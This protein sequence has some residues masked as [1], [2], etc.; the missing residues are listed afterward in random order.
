[1]P[2][3][4]VT[5]SV[6]GVTLDLTGDSP[7]TNTELFEIF[8]QYEQKPPEQVPEPVEDQSI[9]RSVADVPLQFATGIS[10]GVR[11]IS[12]AFGADNAVSQNLR[13]VE[14]YLGSLL[15]AQAQNDRE[16]VGR[17]FQEAQDKGLGEQLAAGLRAIAVS[18]VDFLAQG[19]G[20]AVPT[21]AGGLA[22]AALRGGTLAARAA[23]AKQ[24][25]TGVGV[26]GGAGLTKSTIYDEVK[27]ELSALG[28]LPKEVIEE[29][30]RLAQE[31]GGE[32]LDQILL[33]AGLG[34][35]A[36]GTGIEKVLASRILKNA[37]ARTTGV[38][39]ATK[40]AAF[41]GAKE[42][43]PEFIQA[44][45]EQIAG[46]VALQREG[47][48]DIPTMR[49]VATAAALEGVIGF[50]LG[51]GI[52]VALPAQQ[53]Q[54]YDAARANITN[55][56]DREREALLLA[57]EQKKASEF[58]AALERNNQRRLAGQ[59]QQVNIDA[60][61]AAA[62][63]R[64]SEIAAPNQDEV[65]ELAT[66][67]RG[68][69]VSND[70][71]FGVAYGQKIARTLGDYFPNFGQFSVREGEIRGDA[72]YGPD[73]T[74]ISLGTPTFEVINTEGNRYGQPLLTF[75]QANATAYS[76]NKEVINQN[77]RGAI[78][79][80]LETS[81]QAYDPETTQRLFSYGYRTLNPDANLF[82]TVAI[83]EAAQTVGPQYA[84]A[85][86]WRQLEALPQVKKKGK[87]VGYEYTPDGGQTR[88]ITGLTKAQEINKVRSQE[89]KA[90][91]SVFNLEETRANLGNN[92]S[93]LT[94]DIPID[95]QTTPLSQ[96]TLEFIRNYD[97][98]TGR[99]ITSFYKN[100]VLNA[101]TDLLRSKNVT[102]KIDSPEINALSKSLIGKDSVKGMDYGE[103][104]LFLKKLAG[105]PRFEKPT[106]LP[107]FEFKPYNRENF[108][109]ASKFLQQSNAQGAK[110]DRDQILEAAGISKEDPKVD[111]KFSA[112]E[113]DLA[114]QGVRN[115]PQEPL[116]LPA[117]PGGNIDLESL[118]E[119][120]RAK[121]KGF[122][123]Q[124]IN[125]SLER[126]L[127][128][129]TGEIAPAETEAMF[130]PAMKQVFLAVDR[131]D[132]DGSLTPEQR[133]NA[134]SEVL[135]HEIIHAVRLL[136]L[137]KPTEWSSLE[138]AVAK[139]Q[140]PGTNQTY[141][142]IAQRNYADQNA[143]IQIE[144]AV[145]DMYRDYVGKRL[146]IAGKPQNLLERLSQ[147]FQ[148][149]SSALA[150]T[151]FQTY[152]DV[153][154]RLE[155]GQIGA[156]QR[157]EIRTLR[158]TEEAVAEAGRI[159]ERLKGILA[160]PQ[161]RQQ[162]RQQ[163]TQQSVATAQAT[164]N[165]PATANAGFN[166]N[167]LA[168]AAIRESRSLTDPVPQNIDVDGKN[169]PTR[170]SEGRLIYSG[171][172]GPEVFNT[173]TRPTMDGLRN[174][175]N[176]FGS[177]KA[178]DNS[179]RPLV[180]YHGTAA[181]IT[182]FKPKQ[183]GSVF[184]TRNPR[185]ADEFSSLSE[186]YMV[187][188]FPDFMSDQQ[189]IDSV[190][191]TLQSVSSFTP[192]V[193]DN[194]AAARD[195]AV[196][197][198]ASG[199]AIRPAALK[200]FKNSAS[201][202]SGNRYLNAIQKRLPSQPN[203]MPIYVKAEKSWDYDNKDDVKTVV[204]RARDNGADVTA[205]MVE[206]IGQGNWQTIEGSEGNSP[207]LDAIRELGYDSM[208]IEEA[209]KNL[210][211][212]DPGQIKSAIGNNGDFSPLTPSIRE[213]RLPDTYPTAYQRRSV[214]TPSKATPKDVEMAEEYQNRTGQMPYLSDGQLQPEIPDVRYSIKRPYETKDLAK[215][216][217]ND[218]ILG[219]PLNKNGTVTL[220][221]PATNE[222]ARRTIQDK[223]LKGSTPTSNRIY[224]TNESSGP[225]VM[226]N[227]GNIDQSMD[228]ANVLIQVDPSL[229]HID[230]EYEDGRKDFFIQLAE[231]ESYAKKMKQTKLFTLDAPRTRALSKDTKLV[232]IERSISNAVT[233]YLA[234][235]AK[236]K[237]AR[238]KQARDVLKKEHNVGTLMGENGKLQKTR[239]GDYG[240]TYE[241][242][243]V[244]SM[245]LGLAS[246]QRINEQNLSTC[247]KSA[248][249]EG[250]CLGET[251]GQNYL[252]GGEGQF[253]SGPRLSQYLKT[254]ALVQHPEDFSIVLFEEI[255]RF[256]K[257][258]N[259]E[260][261]V[262]QVENE[263]GE[264][265]MQ[266]KQVYQP[267]I[268]LNVTSD[269]RPQ[270]FASII[271][272]F[273]NVMFYDYTKL[274]TRSIA[275]NHHL[276]YSS[277]GASQIVNGE[278]IV[279]PESNWDRM[280]QQL[281]NGMNVAMAFTSRTD[282]P[283]FVV[284]ERT[285]QRF[286]VWN[287][288][289]YD[290]RFL[291][292]KREDG[293][294]MIVGLTN[295]DKTTKPED[296]AKKY[297]GFF[298]D[299][300]RARD[301]DALVIPNQGRL[302]IGAAPQGPVAEA[303]RPPAA[304]EAR[305]GPP[306]QVQAAQ[307][308]P[309]PAVNTDRTSTAEA[310]NNGQ[311]VNSM[312]VSIG[313]VIGD[314][315]PEGTVD[316]SR[317]RISPLTRR[318][319]SQ[320]IQSAPDKLRAGFGLD[321]L[322]SRIENYYDGY[323]AKLGI[324]N[325]FIRNAYRNIGLGG[326]KSAIETFDRYMRARENKKPNEAL[327]ILN[328]ASENDRQLI[329]AWNKISI[330]TGRINK[331][332][333]TPDGEPMKVYDSK[334][335]DGKGGWRNIGTVGDFFPRTFRREVMEVMKN[336][337]LDPQLWKSLLD[338]LVQ[339]DRADIKTAADAEKYLI[340]EWFS[341]EVK[342]DYFAG[343]EKART[344]A[345]PEIFYDY[346]WD[347]ATRYLNKWARRTSQIEN[348]GQELGKFKKEWFGTNIPNIR[349]QET[350]NYVNTIRERIY[351]IEPFDTLSNMANWLN[352]LAT[353]TQLGNPISAS[354]NLLGGTITNIQEFGIIAVTK[355]YL[356]L[357]TDWRKIQEEG[358][359]LGILNKDFMNIL[360]DHVEMDADKYFSKEQKISQS[361]A[362]FAN[363]A[364][365]FGGFNAAE[366]VVRSSA[367]LA[368][369][370]RLNTFLK[371]VNDNPDSEN[372]KKFYA[373]A[374]R[375]N[376]NIDALILEN[377]S[378]KET[379][380]YMRRAVN[381]PQGSYQIDMTPVFIDTTAGRFFFKY[382]KFGTQINR[383]YYNHFLKPILTEKG[384]RG[385][386]ILRALGF[387][388]TAIVGGGAILAIREAF[389][390]GDPGPDL[391]ELDKA[392][393]DED[394]ARAWALILSRSMENIMAA[395]SFGFFGN[396][397][398]F[399][400]DW[401]DQQR[402][403]NPMN[404]PG[405][406]SV[407]AVIDVFNRLRDQKTIT[408][409]D[410]D[411]IAETTMSFYRANKRI[412]LALMDEIGS[413]AKE[414]ERFSAFKDL[415]EIR[416]YSRR[417]SDEMGIEFKRS[418]APGSPIRTEMTPI[419]KAITDALHVGNA[420]AA[421]LIMREAVMKVPPKDRQQIRQSIQSS[422]RNRQP[423]QVGGNAPSKQER[424]LFIRWAKQNLPKEKV[425]LVIREDREYR[426]AAA[427]IGMGI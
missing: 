181:D 118:R 374:N 354:L 77:V 206:E 168:T 302:R 398:Q 108:V 132:P 20:T 199:K 262:E 142:Q 364:L 293:I 339:S 211:V 11:F 265:V 173:Q 358:T 119:A 427:R 219:L 57:E 131:I 198:V 228:G 386:N 342:N 125:L 300:D 140:K 165:V 197:D 280:I 151:G 220:Y 201:T 80:S 380:K 155:S 127:I 59:D 209:G 200:V 27:R 328:N 172:E 95:L 70:V 217:E 112:L 33:G 394:T 117:P 295:K 141:L 154:N 353:A 65:N 399:A 12:D 101:V 91:S 3:Y 174:F 113:T 183:A 18:P 156:R 350:Q 192:N 179:K 235:D 24:V 426:R 388:G 79:N 99:P 60:E 255:S 52:N 324:V 285:G 326:R 182:E 393:E 93:R 333:R 6:S 278:S 128:K 178:V 134:L 266:P 292:P 90:E 76:L 238:L 152:G 417:F 85:L 236:G 53:Q 377:G 213:S 376:L 369:R 40:A 389:G 86:S 122:G 105:L 15:S 23:T 216:K 19:L 176:W 196:T 258:A 4:R 26:V 304:R 139:T 322:A 2:T 311:P 359:T 375:E 97:A 416:E 210:A 163:A 136:D 355:S 345:L 310:L 214:K 346:S 87:V 137:W 10:Q 120:L 229:L 14:D 21:I 161:G 423:L 316:I 415:R 62:R 240:L 252:Y 50:G 261:G 191:E 149:L 256:Q 349:D 54:K 42:A 275:P 312:G 147:F 22:G 231:G 189:V 313:P 166:A 94:K 223:R 373:Y 66:P 383:F 250:L 110:P 269:F 48:E 294:G 347:A 107:V 323:A 203:V 190:N 16:E 88:I 317:A 158:A 332:V 194:M 338:S 207:I 150:G 43:V 422:I 330:E 114:K 306:R 103:S 109:R 403:K 412:G 406:A 301:G 143:V 367:M 410:L 352:S 319:V 36:A 397:A 215:G 164:G 245:G 102:S 146:K 281:N 225:K 138:K 298:L 286:Q 320:L 234:L 30:A 308:Q 239:L 331:E 106:Q 5:D 351:E 357:L 249:C 381:I 46:N 171:Y 297:K 371:K 396:Y 335:N 315:E 290:A 130:I 425:E 29:R 233:N 205:S 392:L 237:R 7:P 34:G 407:D 272:A 379:E 35:L 39:A 401:Q 61:A 124:D 187:S 253:K 263:A 232:D 160:T 360:R 68:V 92:F 348:F 71:Q 41:T 129:P 175:W 260:T 314:T 268:R 74:A 37:G 418:T 244:A 274:P 254:E 264:Q 69:D 248:I 73:G 104:R 340:R 241:G 78:L 159:P 283:D 8:S 365:T 230:Q 58:I 204:K 247:P 289:N 325:N 419:N 177:S 420:A 157:G 186:D 243:S 32:N 111:E 299:Y 307:T 246:A 121:L 47:F 305:R 227:P 162:V 251:S 193:Y 361:L 226:Q 303:A 421:R 276:T 180:Y 145:A 115:K 368:A 387:V 17:I 378:G 126:N 366:N 270:T 218:P 391:D 384:R 169:V 208:Y 64:A 184:V 153:I 259:S 28:E 63:T 100:A 98:V 382:Q 413:D 408:A 72:T 405:L 327:S 221:Y 148:R 343:V 81:G 9:L 31:Y 51:A 336:P 402:V 195:Q 334:W 89:G 288:D 409:R 395:G 284:D 123:L 329:D 400:K 224:L 222:A 344:Q 25:G 356:D 188:N 242:K 385:R 84:E 341:D 82:S 202:F 273:P 362:R 56:V 133:L 13:G 212:F 337:D 257:W 185:L 287:G 414:V 309:G 267:A 167:L 390:Y 271:N 424:L 372:V 321:N 135:G 404:P 318:L 83:N 55:E 363:T 296:S 370:A 116:A 44:A 282:M 170:D 75:E 1:M 277:T 411:E 49:G 96:P 38:L 279:N 45:Q 144:E 291:D 67:M